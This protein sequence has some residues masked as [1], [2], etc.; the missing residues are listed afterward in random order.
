[1]SQDA[2]GVDG[3]EGR[4]HA[5]VI[6]AGPAGLTAARALANSMDHVTVIERDRLPHGAARRRGVPQARHAHSLTTT[7]QQGLEELFPGIGADFARAGAVRIGLSQDA[8]VLGPAGWLPR[9]DAGLSMLSASRDLIDAVLR[10]RLHAEPKVT[11]LA[12]HEVQGLQPG[13][14]D[15]VTGVWTRRRERPGPHGHG[16]RRLIPADF[17]VDAS[18]H[19]SRAPHWLAD[20]GYEPPRE[21]AVPARTTY[22]STVFAP[23]IGHVADWQSLLLLAAPGHPR[24]GTLNVI[25]GGRLALTLT[26]ADGAPPPT[27]HAGLLH[28]AGLLRHPLLRDVIESATPLG[29]V[30]TCTRTENRWRHYDQL[31]RWPDQFLVVGDA[32]AVTDPAHGQGMTHAVQSALVLD[33]MLSGHG[34]TVGLAYRLRRALA[35]RLAPAWHTSTRHLHT[36][37]P[38][39]VPPPPSTPETPPPPPPQARQPPPAPQTRLAPPAPR[40]RRPLLARQAPQTRRAPPV[41][42]APQARRPPPARVLS[43]PPQARQLPPAPQIRRPPPAAPQTQRV[44]PAP[45][46]RQAPAPQARRLSPTRQPLLA[47]QAPQTRRAPPVPQAPQARRPPPAR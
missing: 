23:P 36:T 24:Q 25:E 33:G 16:P 9:F 8:L 19:T 47:R 41:P 40:P 46:V 12:G 21:T 1:M 30:Y 10:A 45:P 3:S 13:R 26:F 38:A 32:L 11:F 5:V 4:S 31:R 15:T 39:P 43:P 44:P 37:G 35:H 22:A 20:L 17:V 2:R 27:D 42:Q 34:T 14:N 18:G 7:A 29:P 28:A 6:G